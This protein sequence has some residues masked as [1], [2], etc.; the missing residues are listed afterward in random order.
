MHTNA[1][2]RET[3]YY[4]DEYRNLLYTEDEDGITYSNYTCYVA[5]RLEDNQGNIKSYDVDENANVTG[6]YYPN[7]NE[8][9]TSDNLIE[10]VAYIDGSVETYRYNADNSLQSYTDRN[11]NTTSYSYNSSGFL[12][13]VTNALGD[14][15]DYSY[16]SGGNLLYTQDAEGGRVSYDYDAVGRITAVHTKISAAETATTSYTYSNAGKLEKETDAL[17]GV[18]QTEYGTNGQALRQI[19]ANGNATVYA[20]QAGTAKRRLPNG[21][22]N[23]KR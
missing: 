2:G 23:S 16:D 5:S 22:Q 21:R 10:E 9:Y 18:T 3:K 11:G 15:T 12:T 6:I 20:Y 14:A 8:M 1:Q 7:G 4:Y 13:Q 17:G 19:D